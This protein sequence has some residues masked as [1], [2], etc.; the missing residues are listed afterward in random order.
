MIPERPIES[1]FSTSSKNI[2]HLKIDIFLVNEVLKFIVQ[3]C[4]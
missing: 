3:S 1:Q 4:F 2:D